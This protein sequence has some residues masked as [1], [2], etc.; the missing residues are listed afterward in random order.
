[1]SAGTA[2][3]DITVN[4]VTN[5]AAVN[6]DC[7]ANPPAFTNGASAL[8]GLVNVGNG[9]TNQCLVINPTLTVT[10]TPVCFGDAA[11]VDYN[12][13]VLGVGAPTLANIT[14]QKLNGEVVKVL[15]GQ[16]LTGRLLWPGTVLDGAGNPTSWPGIDAS[17]P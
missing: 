8:S 10:A 14:W 5:A 15:S 4:G 6:P 17:A 9:V 1:M 13:T 11:Y 7:T 3:C 2:V 16:P 12:V